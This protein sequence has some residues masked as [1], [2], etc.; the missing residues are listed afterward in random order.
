VNNSRS[1]KWDDCSLR[2]D[3]IKMNLNPLRIGLDS[4]SSG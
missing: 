3:N 2:E 4:S 1:H